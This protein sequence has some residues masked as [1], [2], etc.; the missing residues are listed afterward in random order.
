MKAQLFREF[1]MM[2]TCSEIQDMALECRTKRPCHYNLAENFDRLNNQGKS[3]FICLMV[4]TGV[5]DY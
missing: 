1:S 4:S 3:H 2:K 5:A